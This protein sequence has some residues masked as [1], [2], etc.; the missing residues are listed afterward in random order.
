MAPI[1]K[2]DFKLV[3]NSSTNINKMNYHLSP[4][5][6]E[7]KKKERKQLHMTVEMLFLA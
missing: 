7:H 1:V 3:I 5:F 2:I 6:I 4:Q